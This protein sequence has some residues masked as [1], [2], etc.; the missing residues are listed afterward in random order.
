MR[1]DNVDKTDFY[2]YTS[3][4]R[5]AKFGHKQCLHASILAGAN[6]NARNKNDNTGQSRRTKWAQ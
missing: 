5:A 2:G 4:I 3:L 6:V 1:A